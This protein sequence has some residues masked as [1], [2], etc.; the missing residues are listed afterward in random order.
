[1]KKSGFCVF[2]IKLTFGFALS[3]NLPRIGKHSTEI[4]AA[5]GKDKRLLC[6]VQN[7]HSVDRYTWYKNGK[8]LKTAK[9]SRMRVKIWRYLKIKRIRKEDAGKYICE[10]SNKYGKINITVILHVQGGFKGEKTTFCSD[11]N[12]YP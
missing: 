5:P 8:F 4:W 3:G 6:S 11:I 2:N 10:A 7:Q 9:D 1:M 12:L